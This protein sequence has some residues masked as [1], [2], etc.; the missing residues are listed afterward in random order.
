VL[1]AGGL[2]L[3][4]PWHWLLAKHAQHAPGRMLCLREAGSGHNLIIC[5]G[6]V[7]LLGTRGVQ[8]VQRIMSALLEP[9]EHSPS[10]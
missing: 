4:L 10:F 8:S 7:I 3:P 2:Q 9:I 6:T 1:A 5:D